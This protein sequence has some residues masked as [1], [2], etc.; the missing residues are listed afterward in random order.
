MVKMLYGLKYPVFPVWLSIEFINV[1]DSIC[2][3]DFSEFF[4]IQ[5]IS[6]LIDVRP[7]PNDILCVKKVRRLTR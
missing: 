1:H 4:L 6:E 5:K 2:A 7:K 3:E